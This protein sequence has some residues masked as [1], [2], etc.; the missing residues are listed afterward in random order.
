MLP[1]RRPC[2]LWDAYRLSGIPSSIVR[3]IFADPHARIP[4]PTCRSQTRSG[5]LAGGAAGTT[6]RSGGGCAISLA[7]DLRTYL[8]DVLPRL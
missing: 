4:S 3:R 1:L 6:A 5:G 8:G 7:A 2:R